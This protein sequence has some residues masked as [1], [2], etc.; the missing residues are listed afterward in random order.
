MRRSVHPR[1]GLV[2]LLVIGLVFCGVG[3]L[4]LTRPDA[5]M[6][7]V[8]IV[9]DDL[10]V[11]NEV[12][13]TYG[14]MHLCMGIF[15]VLCALVGSM[16]GAGLVAAL[17]FLGGLAIGRIVS[18]TRDGLPDGNGA[19][20]VLLFLVVELLGALLVVGAL[21]KRRGRLQ[22][23]AAVPAAPVSTEP[24]LSGTERSEPV[25]AEPPPA[26]EPV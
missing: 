26:D 18:L 14:G 23:K 17:A 9:L 8:G 10:R 7:P 22:P 25:A 11:R 16:R 19:L 21:L 1:G 3:W 24:V 12:T 20:V 5:L 6:A 15:F 4:G 2:S 13:A